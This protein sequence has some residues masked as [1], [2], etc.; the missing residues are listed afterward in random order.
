MILKP[1]PTIHPSSP[2][3]TTVPGEHSG[4]T[5]CSCGIVLSTRGSVAQSC[6]DSA[7]SSAGSVGQ[8]GASMG[9]LRYQRWP[10]KKMSLGHDPRFAPLCGSEA[11]I[12]SLNS[13]SGAEGELDNVHAKATWRITSP[14]LLCFAIARICQ[15][16][17]T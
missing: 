6:P 1:A 11:Y 17:H 7:K 3:S 8:T 13:T 10:N 15:C 2:P 5:C 4:P 9:S 12:R 16:F 14:R